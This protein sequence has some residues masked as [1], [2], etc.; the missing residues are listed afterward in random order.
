MNS[1]RKKQFCLAFYQLFMVL[2]VLCFSFRWISF[3]FDTTKKSIFY[4]ICYL[5]YMI[6]L[7]NHLYFMTHSSVKL[8][9]TD[10]RPRQK[11]IK[12]ASKEQLQNQNNLGIG[13]FGE[14]DFTE[15]LG[16]IN[17]SSLKILFLK[18]AITY[19]PSALY[20]MTRVK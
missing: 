16:W 19:F 9:F 15:L 11:K 2:K 6:V 3:V 8:Y 5:F 12:P 4:M 17:K 18:N 10:S 1:I 20:L 14:T 7:K 13:I